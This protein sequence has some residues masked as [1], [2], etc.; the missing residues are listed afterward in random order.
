MRSSDSRAVGDR[1]RGDEQRA[2]AR[3]V[4]HDPA[5]LEAPLLQPRRRQLR[6]W[7]RWAPY[8]LDDAIE[9]EITRS[10]V[11]YVSARVAQLHAMNEPGS[12]TDLARAE[13][14]LRSLDE[15]AADR[16]DNDRAAAAIFAMRSPV[17]ADLL[18]DLTAHHVEDDVRR[19]IADWRLRG[20]VVDG[21]SLDAVRGCAH[22]VRAAL[23]VAHRWFAARSS[24]IGRSYSDRRLAGA[25][26]DGDLEGHAIAAAVAL[27]RQLPVLAPVAARAAKLAEAGPR[28]EVSVDHDGRITMMVDQRPTARARL[29][30]AHELGH[31]VHAIC[32]R[33]A[34]VLEAPGV[35][36]AETVACW[37]ALACGAQWARSDGATWAIAL[38][39]HL[40][41]EVFM[42]AALSEFEDQMQS[43]VRA[44]ERWT[45]AEADET[46]Y[47]LLVELYGGAIAVPQWAATGWARH[48]DL[49]TEPGAPMRYVWATLL[50]LAAADDQRMPAV[51]TRSIEA[52]ELPGAL[53]VEPT[54]WWVAGTAALE[55]T[56]DGL[57][58]AIEVG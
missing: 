1:R 7:S 12:A 8:L 57:I 26:G 15:P 49:A 47:R 34:G 4:F 48:V 42:S 24:V 25:I 39:D 3:A 28:N 35:L 52:D 53:G 50:A 29:M 30:T 9:A 19:G 6:A 11:P 43:T 33:T 23:P 17:M 38:G 14:L 32:G 55:A 13:T 51:L 5:L 2:A 54:D 10:T 18:H 46:W 40:I 16:A 44:G 58:R 27:A 20:A 37:T 56:I 21:T 41:N 45:A 31:A 22:A 36:V